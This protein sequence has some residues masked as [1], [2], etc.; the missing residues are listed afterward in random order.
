MESIDKFYVILDDPRI[1]VPDESVSNRVIRLS[2]IDGLG[3]LTLSSP[4]DFERDMP[5]Q[6]SC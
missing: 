3:G 2:A 4:E 1:P 5:N 6:D